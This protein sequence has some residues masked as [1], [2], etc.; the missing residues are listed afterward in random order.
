MQLGLYLLRDEVFQKQRTLD[1][2]FRRNRRDSQQ[3]RSSS[4]QVKE[5]ISNALLPLNCFRRT[6]LTCE[7]IR[8]TV[9]CEKELKEVPPETMARNIVWLFSTCGF[10]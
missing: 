9:S 4:E 6:P 5:N 10:W 3:T 1:D 7:K 2:P 8:L